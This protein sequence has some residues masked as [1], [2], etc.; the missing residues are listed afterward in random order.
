MSLAKFVEKVEREER[1]K[2][3]RQGVNRAQY[4][5]RLG[6]DRWNASEDLNKGR[7]DERRWKLN[8]TEEKQIGESKKRE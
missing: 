2:L 8:E 3:N 6:F 7:R 1:E 5:I 4:G